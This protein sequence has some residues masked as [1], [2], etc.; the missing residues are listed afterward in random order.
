MRHRRTDDRHFQ[1]FQSLRVS[2]KRNLPVGL[3]PSLQVKVGN[4]HAANKENMVQS[5]GATEF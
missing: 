2:S 5:K 3:E 4:S 1:Y